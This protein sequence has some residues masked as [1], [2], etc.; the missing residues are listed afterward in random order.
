MTT[1]DSPISERVAVGAA[2]L[3][4]IDPVWPKRIDLEH[5][6]LFVSEYS[7]QGSRTCGCVL[8]QLDYRRPGRSVHD[9][10]S[11]SNAL[12]SWVGKPDA[13]LSWE[14]AHGFNGGEEGFHALTEAWRGL[15]RSRR[16]S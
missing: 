15:I 5:L 4:R 8:A 9:Y 13:T 6:D 7:P 10:G 2:W 3:D 12:Y 1:P 14:V 11:Y 16:E